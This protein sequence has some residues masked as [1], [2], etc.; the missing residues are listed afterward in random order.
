LIDDDKKR[1]GL[2]DYLA[3]LAC[4][5]DS[6]A[7]WIAQGILARAIRYDGT[8]ED[9]L[10]EIPGDTD[11][12]KDRAR[13]VEL[14]GR[15]RTWSAGEAKPSYSFNGDPARLYVRLTEPDCRVAA[16]L[17]EYVPGDLNRLEKEKATREKV[18]VH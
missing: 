15:G 12:Q 14:G 10:P 16:K 18:H 13:I 4:T 2:S 17:Q 11:V 1:A 6:D 5:D 7:G 9:V 3:S 8:M